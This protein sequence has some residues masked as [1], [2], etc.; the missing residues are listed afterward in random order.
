MQFAILDGRARDA[1]LMNGKQLALLVDRL[2]DFLKQVPLDNDEYAR[3][4]VELALAAEEH[5]PREQAIAI[6][7]RLGAAL[8]G[9][10]D[11]NDRQHL[12]HD[13]GRC[14]AA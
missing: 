10:N 6:Y 12:R 9:S 13:A 5:Q 14:A 11:V 3:L 2:I 1:A 4:A 7:T 8:A